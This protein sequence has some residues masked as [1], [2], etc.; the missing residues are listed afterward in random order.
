MIADKRKTEDRYEHLLEIDESLYAGDEDML[1]ILQ[2]LHDVAHDPEVL[3][4]MNLEDK[5]F[6]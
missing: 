1:Y 5:S 2:R 6:R 4:R 3:L